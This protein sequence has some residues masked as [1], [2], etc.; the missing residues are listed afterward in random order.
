MG[1]EKWFEKWFNVKILAVMGK[2]IVLVLKITGN[3]SVIRDT[4]VWLLKLLLI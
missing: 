2:P 3:R 4:L 1:T